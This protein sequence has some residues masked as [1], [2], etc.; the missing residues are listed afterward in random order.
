MLRL[1]R[2]LAADLVKVLLEHVVGSRSVGE[3]F[4]KRTRNR[5]GVQHQK[6]VGHWGRD[7]VDQTSDLLKMFNWLPGLVGLLLVALPFDEITTDA[8]AERCKQSDP[9]LQTRR[10]SD[11]FLSA[12]RD[13]LRLARTSLSNL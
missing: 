10:A 9:H 3:D 11:A 7:G 13:G 5:R 2:G 4:S 6:G 8:L 1:R 12:I